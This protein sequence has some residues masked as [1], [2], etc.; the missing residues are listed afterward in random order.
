MEKT[1]RSL[2]QL[3]GIDFEELKKFYKDQKD[4]YKAIASLKFN[5]LYNEVT[6]DMRHEIKR[7]SFITMY[8]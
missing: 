2:A 1:L 8:S 4:I 3:H 6:L 5:V 7:Q